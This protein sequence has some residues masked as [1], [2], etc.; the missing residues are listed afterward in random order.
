MHMHKRI[1]HMRS[2]IQMHPS[3]GMAIGV[4]ERLHF[5]VPG[6]GESMLE[7]THSSRL[8]ATVDT[9]GRAHREVFA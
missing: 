8:H 7:H 1:R 2:R 3:L 5:C 6:L 9:W 4:S